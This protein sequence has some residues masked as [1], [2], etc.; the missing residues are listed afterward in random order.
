MIRVH[1]CSF[2]VHNKETKSMSTTK[3]FLDWLHVDKGGME[4][5]YDPERISDE[6]RAIIERNKKMFGIYPDLSGHG[7]KRNRLP[8][9]ITIAVEPARKSTSWLIEDQPWEKS[10]LWVTVIHD[11]GK[12]RCWYSV[13][14]PKPLGGENAE[15]T[16]HEGRQMDV[17]K[18]GLCYAESADGRPALGQAADGAVGLRGLEGQ[19]HRR[20]LADERDRHL[21]R[22]VR[23]GR[24]AL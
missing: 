21:P 23:P 7:M 6:G 10:L 14:F 17:G 20:H 19:Q 16:F 12:Y 1:S 5:T 8:F 13:A 9:G 11:E 22:S 4:A 18:Y 15:Q 24:R 2:V 3:L